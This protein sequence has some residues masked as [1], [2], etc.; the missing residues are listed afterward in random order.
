MMNRITLKEYF[1]NGFN[2]VLD[3]ELNK[4]LT[5]ET[6]EEIDKEIL[7]KNNINYN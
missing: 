5:K 1:N 6:V 7:Q 4:I 2:T 3:K